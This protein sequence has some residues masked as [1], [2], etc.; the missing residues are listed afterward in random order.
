[1]LRPRDPYAYW[2]GGV[3]SYCWS[4]AVDGFAHDRQN[5]KS[6]SSRLTHPHWSPWMGWGSADGCG[7]GDDGAD[8]S[9]VS[10][11]ERGP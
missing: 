6:G 9:D 11:K 5:R 8:V 1:M 3:R 10:D 2:A 4:G 7:D